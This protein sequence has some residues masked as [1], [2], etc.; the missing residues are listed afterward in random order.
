MRPV[1]YFSDE[2]LEQCRSMTPEQIVQFLE[3][4]RILHQPQ[5]G[6]S[7]LISIKVPEALLAAFKVK[8][9]LSGSPYQTQI[10]RLMTQWL[11]DRQ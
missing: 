7:R 4:F 10:K 6:P 8:A 2:Y 1:Q 11:G 5:P 3:D 9:R